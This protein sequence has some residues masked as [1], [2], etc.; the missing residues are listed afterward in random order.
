MLMRLYI[1]SN[2]EEEDEDISEEEELEEGV[3]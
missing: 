3:E 1:M 2:Q